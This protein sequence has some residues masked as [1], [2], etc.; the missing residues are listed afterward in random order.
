MTDQGYSVSQNEIVND[1]LTKNL[2]LKE[3]E[4]RLIN[5]FIVQIS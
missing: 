5:D 2:I 4:F 3:N 1:F